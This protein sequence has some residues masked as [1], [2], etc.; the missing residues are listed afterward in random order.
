MMMFASDLDR[1]L[2]YSQKMIDASEEQPDEIRVAETKNGE[3]ITYITEKTIHLLKQVSERAMFVPVT[4]RTTEQYS[5]IDVICKDIMPKYAV[6]GNGGNILMQGKADMAWHEL[7]KGKIENECLSIGD[8]LNE[9]EKIKSDQWVKMS[10]VADELFFY[11]VVHTAQVPK[12]EVCGYSEYLEENNWRIA[13]HGRKLYFIPNCVNKRDAVA[14]LAEQEGLTTKIIS[15]GDSVLDLD[16]AEISNLFIS[17][18]HGEICQ[19]HREEDDGVTY[20]KNYGITASD[21]LLENI[22]SVLDG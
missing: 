9:F 11:C 5:R 16:M 4:T 20:T 18:C 13:L 17:P 7:I 6:T 3:V 10:R 14:H 2:I 19:S 12:D 1:T 21:E 22:I 15:A 8:A